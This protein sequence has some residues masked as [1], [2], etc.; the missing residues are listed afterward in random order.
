MLS[1]EI[2]FLT[3]SENETILTLVRVLPSTEVRTHLSTLLGEV[4]TG[5]E[6]VITFGKKREIIAVIV[7]YV[8]HKLSKK[9][10]LGSLKKKMKV[11]AAHDFKMAD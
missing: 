1:A 6:M 2:S 10:R 4:Q 9:R 8:N 7:P 3:K 11:I 5:S